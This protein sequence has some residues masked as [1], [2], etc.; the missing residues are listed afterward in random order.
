MEPGLVILDSDGPVVL[1]PWN[2]GAYILHFA[3]NGSSPD[4]LPVLFGDG[5]EEYDFRWQWQER[6]LWARSS[7][8]WKAYHL[9]DM[10]LSPSSFEEPFWVVESTSTEPHPVRGIVR[11]ANKRKAHSYRIEHVWRDPW[12]LTEERQVSDW[13]QG[14]PP[15]SFGPIVS[16]KDL[17]VSPNGRHAVVVEE[18]ME[19]NADDAQAKPVE[20]SYARRVDLRLAPPLPS[21]EPDADAEAAKDRARFI[22]LRRAYEA[23]NQEEAAVA[24]ASGSSAAT[25]AKGEAAAAEEPPPRH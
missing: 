16:E 9:W 17:F 2:E 5:V 15:S 18:I 10:G 12:S 8:Y 13:Y 23:K 4:V 20:I 25:Q 22:S 19:K 6:I 7:L 24:A 21:I 1:S 11:V 3:E 14:K